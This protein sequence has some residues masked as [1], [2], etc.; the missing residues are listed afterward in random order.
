MGPDGISGEF[1][2]LGG[3]AM[4]PYLARLLDIT[5]NNGTLPV[6]WKRAIEFPIHKGVIVHWS[7]IIDRLI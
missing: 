4:I 1:L 7:R 6:D 5:V 3:E 2:K